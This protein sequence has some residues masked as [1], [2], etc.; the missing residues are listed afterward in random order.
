MRRSIFKY[1]FAAIFVVVLASVA[2][3]G[4]RHITSAE[5]MTAAKHFVELASRGDFSE[6]QKHCSSGLQAHFSEADFDKMSEE[7]PRD[8][9]RSIK[10]VGSSWE[11]GSNKATTL[12]YSLLYEYPKDW[13]LVDLFLVEADD[14]PKI[15][16]IGVVSVSAEKIQAIRA[17]LLGKP[18]VQLFLLVVVTSA[19]IFV[20][21]WM[22]NWM[23]QRFMG[24]SSNVRRRWIVLS[25]ILAV[26]ILWYFDDAELL[27]LQIRLMTMA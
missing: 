14:G 25:V 26:G 8:P 24:K 6:F 12:G 10:L 2:Y 18:V 4:H 5:N 9:A 3:V 15:N 7:F 22:M 23:A 1:A 20:W 19:M 16:G 21:C 17:T 11:A 13:V 27:A